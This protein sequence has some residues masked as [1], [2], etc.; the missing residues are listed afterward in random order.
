M[1]L[2]YHRLPQLCVWIGLG[3]AI[4]TLALRYGVERRSR[5]VGMVVDYAQVRTLAAATAT[6]LEAV[7]RRMRAASVTGVAVGEETLADLYTDGTLDLQHVTTDRGPEQR[8]A[9]A[10]PRA[11]ERVITAVEQLLPSARRARPK[12]ECIVFEGAGRRL[13]VP[14]RFED[15]RLTPT[16]IDGAAVA[17]VRAAGLEPVGRLNNSLGLRLGSLLWSLHRVRAQGVRTLIFAGEEVMGYDRLLGDTAAAIRNADLTYGS[18]EF[19]KQ[20]GDEALSRL[21]TDR[22]LRVHSISAAEMTR[23]SPAEAIERYTRAA[24]ER[25]IRLLYV[26]LPATPSVNTLEDNLA[27]LRE[28]AHRLVAAKLGIGA[29]RLFETPWSTPFLAPVLRALLGV[30]LAGGLVLLLAG[31]APVRR[32]RQAILSIALAMPLGFGAAIGSGLVLQ[33]VALAAAVTFPTLAFVRERQAMAAFAPE[34]PAGGK[35]RRRSLATALL[36]FIRIS[37]VTLVGALF[38][39]AAL[40]DVAYFLKVRS[41]AGIK[42]ATVAPILLVGWIYATGMGPEYG[43][44]REEWAAMR[45]R[46]QAIISEPIRVGY[47]VAVI[48]GVGLLALLL[49]RS[50]NDSGLGVSTFELR[51]RSILDQIVGVRP[52]TKEFLIGHP[53]LILSLVLV[54][55]ARYRMLVLPLLLVGIIGQVGMLNSFCHLHTP[56]KISL[57]RTWNGL[58]T[59]GLLGVALVLVWQRVFPHTRGRPTDSGDRGVTGASGYP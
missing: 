49:A 56:L 22:L 1:A 6:P 33:L 57:L 26:R 16:G 28:L 11:A 7:L 54:G 47:F 37:A 50:G 39:A 19:G 23:L 41:F 38:V 13:W 31:I 21:L 18:V 52:R 40:C 3:A 17:Q 32:S 34:E 35:G 10:D 4:C 42:I 45:R 53:L 5:A 12:G 24:V 59:G 48:L 14:G 27:Y 46:L 29:A 9:F 55:Q 15:I 58:W 25:N 2:R 20:R 43:T 30:G 36:V 8:V 44:L 51:F